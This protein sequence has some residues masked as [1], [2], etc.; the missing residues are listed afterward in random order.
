[1]I[2]IERTAN[3]THLNSQG[4]DS[5]HQATIQD[6]HSQ[7]FNEVIVTRLSQVYISDVIK[8]IYV[9]HMAQQPQPAFSSPE[10]VNRIFSQLNDFKTFSPHFQGNTFNNLS[11]FAR[12]SDFDRPFPF[13]NSIDAVD[14]TK[15]FYDANG[16]IGQFNGVNQSHLLPVVGQT[17]FLS[18]TA[19]QNLMM[20]PFNNPYSMNLVQPQMHSMGPTIMQPTMYNMTLSPGIVP[21]YGMGMSL[22]NPMM[23]PNSG[24]F[25]PYA[26]GDLTAESNRNAETEARRGSMDDAMRTTNYDRLRTEAEDYEDKLTKLKEM[27]KKLELGR[28]LQ[29]QIDEKAK[30]RKLEQERRKM[31]QMEEDRRIMRENEE[32]ERRQMAESSK[33]KAKI[34]DNYNSYN[35]YQASLKASK[36]GANL[37]TKVNKKKEEPGLLLSLIHI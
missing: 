18:T 6:A 25:G 36:N 33:L 15:S 34:I 3:F 37:Y 24:G 2:Q 14:T 16:S 11:G 27:E 31:F 29:E 12:N 22:M 13:P 30:K 26:A 5:T 32:L 19:S 4:N 10:L 35:E 1:M 8:K 20:N 23:I 7:P 21:A 9:Y 28:A 17:S